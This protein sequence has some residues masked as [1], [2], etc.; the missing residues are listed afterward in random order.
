MTISNVAPSITAS[1][2]QLLNTDGGAV[3]VPSVEQDETTDF[4]TH[5][6]VTDY[7][8][9][10]N[11]S[12][13]NE[14]SSAILHVYR[15]GVL[16]VNC[17]G[18]DSDNAN[19]CYQNA[20]SGNGG[21][22]FQDA[23]IDSCG[24]SSDATVGWTCEFP[25]QYH[26]DPTVASNTQYPTEN[27]LTSIK[28]TDNNSADTGLVEDADGAEMDKFVSY[29][30][31]TASVDYGNVAPD[32]ESSDV[33]STLEATGNVGLDAEYSGTDMS[34]ASTTPIAVGQQ[35]YDLTGSKTW[36]NMDY[37]LSVTS[38]P[39]ELNCEKTILSGT[40]KT[41]NTFFKLK[42]PAGQ[43]PGDYTGTDTFVGIEGE[44]ASW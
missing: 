14:I 5:F 18:N 19:D 29:D 9:C 4:L 30:L 6:I 11:V 34:Y 42:V 25:L 32:A 33:T 2:I 35:K 1:S 28:A 31:N 8:S 37:T 36:T 21:R 10:V 39:Q 22:C 12:S 7:N 3:L 17:D 20:Q 43:E 26:P 24:G 44:S 27:W 23:A 41:K 16:S 38:T 13:T 40:P 15:S